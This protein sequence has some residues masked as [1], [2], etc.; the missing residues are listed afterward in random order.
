M[1]IWIVSYP[2]AGKVG[3]CSLEKKHKSWAQFYRKSDGVNE[4]DRYA[5]IHQE[6]ISS[7][8]S[9]R[10][11]KILEAGCGPAIFSIYLSRFGA[12]LEKYL[13]VQYDFQC[14]ALDNDT[15]ILKIAEKNNRDL[16]G[17]VQFVLGDIKQLP[18][19]NLSFD[20][21]FSQGVLEHFSNN[22]IELILDEQLR[23]AKTVLFSV[24][25]FFYHAKDFGNER[26]LF[27]WQWK[28]ILRKYHIM[29]SR[30]YY[31][32]RRKKNFFLKLPQMYYAKVK[33]GHPTT[34]VSHRSE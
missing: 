25:H 5:Q 13:G 17:I 26:L 14:T 16:K 12:H 11:K 19:N 10:P 15:E 31:R 2:R 29:E 22:E 24:P 30:C 1:V 18:F 27:E 20:L 6:L 33:A 9:E 4:I 7:I 3:G 28:R 34:S 23:V 32:I 8:L 21:S